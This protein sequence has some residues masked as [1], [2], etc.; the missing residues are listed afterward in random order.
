[1]RLSTFKIAL[2][3]LQAAI[4][5]PSACCKLQFSRGKLI[6]PRNKLLPARDKLH[7]TRGKLISSRDERLSARDKLYATRIQ[8]SHVTECYPLSNRQSCPR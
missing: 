4:T 2:R 7:L 6:S 5:M 3:T 1:M 8:L